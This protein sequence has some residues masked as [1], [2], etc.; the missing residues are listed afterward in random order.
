MTKPSSRPKNARVA[1]P[2]PFPGTG[3]TSGKLLKSIKINEN[4]QKPIK[5]KE[6]RWKSKKTRPQRWQN[7]LQNLKMHAWP[8]RG[9]SAGNSM[10]HRLRPNATNTKSKK[11]TQNINIPL[12]KEWTVGVIF[13]WPYIY[14]GWK[15]SFHHSVILMGASGLTSGKPPFSF[16]DPSGN[17][18]FWNMYVFFY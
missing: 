4:Q 12:Q 14:E 6:N 9:R 15:I 17:R 16:R 3:S 10:W 5:I 18:C 8:C 11:Y 13:T 7:L 1:V 2:W